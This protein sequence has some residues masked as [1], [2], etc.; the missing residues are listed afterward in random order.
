MD[1]FPSWR[2]V[3]ATC[4]WG[5][6]GAARKGRPWSI[7]FFLSFISPSHLFNVAIIVFYSFLRTAGGYFPVFGPAWS[8]GTPRHCPRRS[9]RPN[10]QL[11]CFQYRSIIP[12]QPEPFVPPQRPK[13][14][15]FTA[16]P[17]RIVDVK[18]NYHSSFVLFCSTWLL[19][20]F[21]RSRTRPR[22]HP[23]PRLSILGLY[24]L[25]FYWV[26]GSHGRHK[27]A[28]QSFHSSSPVSVWI[29]GVSD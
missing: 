20:R 10:V 26:V 21:P 1:A 18:G 8:T 29:L 28:K 17:L 2:D 12:L 11:I 3:P 19:D 22:T 16:L 14:T 15:T 25:F 24:L 5:W 27:W 7:C 9:K 13:R 23:W 6:S 4:E